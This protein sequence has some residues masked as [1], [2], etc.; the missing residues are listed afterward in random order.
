MLRRTCAT[1]GDDLPRRLSH[2]GH[3]APFDARPAGPDLDSPRPRAPKVRSG[4]RSCLRR[5]PRLR[6]GPL[7]SSV[8]GRPRS[9]PRRNTRFWSLFPSAPRRRY[10]VVAVY[11]LIYTPKS[12][13]HEPASLRH[14]QPRGG[15]GARAEGARD[16]P[17][18]G[19][20][21]PEQRTAR[22]AQPRDSVGSSNGDEA[23]PDERSDEQE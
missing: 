7:K 21:W 8:G 17:R 23:K 22:D 11:P 3:T 9:F 18:G 5:P 12:R 4:G 13:R 14:A 1:S 6:G 15:R 19:S 2:R 16:K 10:G 20:C